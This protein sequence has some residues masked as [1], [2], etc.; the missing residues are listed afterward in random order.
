MIHAALI[1]SKARLPTP[2]HNR[3]RLR[4][5]Q[6]QKGFTIIELLVVFSV[7]S[8]IAGIGFATFSSYSDSQKLSGSIKT[9]E[10]SIDDAKNSALSNVK[11]KTT[12]G[13]QVIACTQSVNSYE[14]N[15]CSDVS[16]CSGS[17]YDYEVVLVCGNQRYAIKTGNFQSGVDFGSQ[18]PEDCDS[19]IFST[20]SGEV[21]LDPNIA[22]CQI[23]VTNGNSTKIFL[24]DHTGVL[25]EE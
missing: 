8:I 22:N 19:I 15:L 10:S 6:L 12:R 20:L 24:V 1:H 16:N 3:M 23:S 5:V 17:G 4:S 21:N 9:L 2:I 14:I 11:P 18:D 7:I 25:H 13:G